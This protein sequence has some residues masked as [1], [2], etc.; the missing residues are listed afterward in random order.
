MLEVGGSALLPHKHTAFPVICGRSDR[1]LR[2]VPG[3]R[4]AGRGM[5]PVNPSLT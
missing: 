2:V 3:S 1:A 4:K 5:M